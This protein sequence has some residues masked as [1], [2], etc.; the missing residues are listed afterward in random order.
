[1]TYKTILVH[2]NDERRVAG[3]VDAACQLGERFGAHVIA[4]YV[5][6][7]VPTYGPTGFGAGM[8]Q[9]GLKA[10]REEAERVH[11]AFEGACQGRTIV[12]EWVLVDPGEASVADCV[13]AHARC[14]DLV[15]AGQRDRSFDF[16]QVLD[17]P[18]RIIM[19]SGRPVL[20]IP[21]AGRFPVI[22]KRVS[23]AWNTRREATRA[24][25]DAM[26]LLTAADN[27]RII[28]INPQKERALAGDLPGVEIAATLARHGVRC[29]T[30]TSVATDIQVGDVMLS[31]L[32]DDGADLLVM[33]AWGH[34]RFR[35]V[36]F[37][38]VTRHILEHMT[39]PVLMSH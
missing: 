4:L 23:I 7:P 36:V 31:G 32:S 8:I 30:A 2:I 29:E 34:S 38:G 9:S 17:V 10:F 26:P 33:G 13:I 16:S 21:N 35:E 28:W 12:P 3:L 15:I 39:V 1:M 18:E 5:M 25:F 22:G 37:G 14:S 6:P 20:M 27:V 24:V 11:K 19:E